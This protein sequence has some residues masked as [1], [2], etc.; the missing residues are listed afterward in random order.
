M[1]TNN[2]FDRKN[3]VFFSKENNVEE[4][5]AVGAGASQGLTITIDVNPNEYVSRVYPYY[6]AIVST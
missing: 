6:G 1:V 4:E 3:V 2:K 5:N